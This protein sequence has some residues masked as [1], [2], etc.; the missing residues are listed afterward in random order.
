MTSL[1]DATTAADAAGT[2]ASIAPRTTTTNG[3]IAIDLDGTLLAPDGSVRPRTGTAL[4]A[5]Q[6]AGWTIVLATGRPPHLVRILGDELTSIRYCVAVNGAM[7]YDLAHDDVLHSLTF[8]ADVARALIRQLHA[9][10]PRFG[11]ALATEQGFAHEAGF[12][13][14]LPTPEESPVA[15]DAA[16]LAGDFALK[17]F[18]FH[19]DRSVHDLLEELPAVLA[20]LGFEHLDVTHLGADACEIGPAGVDKSVGLAWLCDR[21]GVDRSRAMAIGDEL[22]DLAMIR[23]AGTGIAMANAPTEIHS[24]ADHVIPSNADDGVARLLEA[25]VDGQFT[26]F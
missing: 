10:D 4:R 16:A 24:V 5:A 7:V 9:Q 14:R 2:D 8:P 3:L 12:S 17:L 6:A 21:L 15:A 23:W 13:D 25:L 1:P 11:F 20:D 26:P 19:L 18:T 22:N